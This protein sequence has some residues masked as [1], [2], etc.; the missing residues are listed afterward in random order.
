M[1]RKPN[2]VEQGCFLNLW[3]EHCAY[4][5]SASLLKTLPTEGGDVILGPGD[6]AGVVR[7]TD[8]LYLAV[9]MESHNHPS[10][11][12]PYNG[13]ATGVGGIVR[14]ILSM[15]ARPIALMN[16]LYFGSL[17]VEKNRY[18]LEHVV[19]GIA[20]YG[21]CIGVPVVGGEVVFQGGYTGNPLVNVVCIGLVAKEH[22]VTATAQRAGDRI[23]L[24]GSSTGRDGLGGA[25]FA[26]RDLTSDSESE[27]GS[28]QI[29]DP[30]TEKL[31]IEAV[32]EAVHMGIVEAC[33]DL[34]AAGL[35]GATCEM[36]AKGDL[37][38]VLD[39]DR[40]HLR[41]EGLTAFEILIAE[42]Q[43]RMVL[44][45]KPDNVENLLMIAEKYD[46][47]ASVIGELTTDT[48]YTI[49]HKG[50]IVAAIPVHL[51]SGGAPISESPSKPTPRVT[52]T[53]PPEPKHI[54][55]DPYIGTYGSMVENT[56]NITTTGATPLCAVNCLNFGNPEKK[57]NY[58]QLKEATRGLGDAARKLGIPIIGGN[59]SLYNDSREHNTSIPPTPSI[60]IIG[61][62]KKIDN[63]PT[64]TIQQS[65]ET[66]ILI[67]ETK[68]ELGASEYYH[69]LNT[70]AGSAPTVPAD[71]DTRLAIIRK[72][73]QT[74]TVATAHDISNGGLATAL[75]ELITPT[76]GAEITLIN[77]N[78][79]ET[80]L[81]FSETHGRMLI[82]TTKPGETLKHLKE[83][84]HA[85]I[86][87]TTKKPQLQITTRREK[88]T[89]EFEEIHKARE[90]L[91][92][93]M[94]E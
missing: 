33:R 36:A 5:S 83:I 11:V 42:S 78:L 67:G 7:L 13:A 86:G 9:G 39:L 62:L 6:D 35:A 54:E 43:E 85:T 16:P 14:D 66:I 27:R 87:T 12:D 18:L 29:G 88:I 74:D 28:V 41:A 23:I 69:T 20:G 4:R 37:G 47:N 80:E 1:G 70:K 89:L 84:P 65:N 79:S 77:H 82:T 55:H 57:E 45:V 34:G 15:G 72:L 22:L 76:H 58:Y 90:T 49:F 73:I 92:R 94:I 50:V 31:L 81:L 75:S 2:L 3:S 19:S 44:E 25:S 56:V 48:N 68:P 71:I 17:S 38:M 64:N 30:Y 32:L 91:T 61:K 63:I 24:L 60:A 21:N 10:Y 53:I 40:V 59:V 52:A 46:L 8:S 26:S 51:L 93:M